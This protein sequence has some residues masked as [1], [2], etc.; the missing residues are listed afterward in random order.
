MNQAVGKAYPSTQVR[1]ANPQQRTAALLHHLF[2]DD[3]REVRVAPIVHVLV[4]GASD[5]APVNRRI[6]EQD[7]ESLLN[8]ERQV[9]GADIAQEAFVYRRR[10]DRGHDGGLFPNLRELITRDRLTGDVLVGNILIAGIA[11]L[12]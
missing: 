5:D 8:R 3:P 10:P 7:A 1:A 9:Q 11:E 6:P 2:F 4:G 12:D